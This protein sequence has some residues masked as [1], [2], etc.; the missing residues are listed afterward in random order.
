VRSSIRRIEPLFYGKHA[1]VQTMAAA[2]LI[3]LH[4]W[5]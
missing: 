2:A 5:K 3:R 1:A 4:R